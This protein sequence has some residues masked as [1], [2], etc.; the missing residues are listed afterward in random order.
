MAALVANLLRRSRGTALGDDSPLDMRDGAVH[1]TTASN[2][3]RPTINTRETPDPSVA[4]ER[5]RL[6]CDFFCSPF[7]MQVAAHNR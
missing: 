3:K 6:R 5:A 4:A 2:G 1:P 7:C